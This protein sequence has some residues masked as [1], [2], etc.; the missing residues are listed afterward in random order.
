MQHEEDEDCNDDDVEEAREAGGMEEL[1][2]G[3][4]DA[5]LLDIG[6]GTDP[7][8]G[9]PPPAA[10]LGDLLGGQNVPSS[11]RNESESGATADL[12]GL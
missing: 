8:G 3:L 7:T 4:G 5:N 1:L 2:A 6:N 12:L 10:P 9:I 11:Q